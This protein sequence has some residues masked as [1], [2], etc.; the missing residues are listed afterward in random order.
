VRRELETQGVAPPTS[1][2]KLR[3]S[4]LGRA[5]R[6]EKVIARNIKG[7]LREEIWRATGKKNPW[8]VGKGKNPLWEYN[9]RISGRKSCA[10]ACRREKESVSK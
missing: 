5:C 4:P 9:Q 10:Q 6:K 1:I 7:G 8:K 2:F 3:S